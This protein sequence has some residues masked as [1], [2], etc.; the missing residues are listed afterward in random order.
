[1]QFKNTYLQYGAV[2]KFF[3]WLIFFMVA[4]LLVVGTIMSDMEF[5]PQMLELYGLHKAIGIMLLA[6]VVLR[7][8]WKM[9]NISPT[10]PDTLNAM[11][12]LGAK[13]AHWLLYGLLVAMPLS[14]WA[15]SSAA[16]FP[17]SVFGLFTLPDLVGK[18]EDLHDFFEDA[19]EIMANGLMLLVGLHSL[20]ALVHHFYYKDN[21]LRSMLPFVRVKN[22]QNH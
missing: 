4:G 6:L 14:G 3:H 11:Q 22:E 15:M 18:S 21:V 20:A 19:H 12:K 13:S 1:M 7:V 5:S 10:L 8:L 9:V 16:G 17:V 2:A